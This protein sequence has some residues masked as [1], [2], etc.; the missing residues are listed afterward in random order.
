[1]AVINYRK[2]IQDLLITELKALTHADGTK[3]LLADVLP[4]MVEK[5]PKTPIGEL[6]PVSLDVEVEG[7]NEDTRRYT[8]ALVVYDSVGA[9][10]TNASAASV[11]NRLMNIEDMII[12]YIEQI[13]H[14]KETAISGI[15]IYNWAISNSNITAVPR[16]SG[17]GFALQIN[18]VLS[19]LINNKLLN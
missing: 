9:K 8:Y 17:I 16:E 4:V 1:M 14:P 13:P 5:A 10:A 11:L 12:R 2:P 3:K 15:H 7:M 18:I 19:V 6:L